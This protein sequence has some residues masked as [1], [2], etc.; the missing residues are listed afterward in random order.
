[1]NL[2]QIDEAI[3]A[4]I[5]T[6]TG[7]VVDP[8]KLNDLF[9]ERNRKIENVACW[10][11]NLT[12][13]AEAYKR[14]KEAFAEREKAAK[15]KADSL[16]KWLTV[17]LD[18]KKFS[19]TKCAVSFRKSVVVDVDENAALPVEYTKVKQEIAPDKT[20]IKKALQEGMEIAGCTLVENLNIQIK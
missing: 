10:Y 20:A 17:A 19:T 12:A 3:M 7:E 9:M 1:M 14:E 18:G 8:E 2:F 13:D 16:K 15:T 6:E 4:C 5:D 11:K